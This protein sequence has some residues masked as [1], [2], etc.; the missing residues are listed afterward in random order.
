MIF[1]INPS[2]IGNKLNMKKSEFNNLIKSRKN[3]FNNL[4]NTELI[5]VKKQFPYCEIIY[6]IVLIKAYL[7]N[8]LNFNDIL[9]DCAVRSSNRQNLFKLIHPTKKIN[10]KNKHLE[11]SFEDWLKNSSKKKHVKTTNSFISQSVE[12]SVKNDLNLTT[13][14]LAKIY[15][16]QGHYERAIQAYKVLCLKYP[17]KSGFFANRI[18]EIR[19]KIK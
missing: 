19:N 12:K 9:S 5:S 15:T 11:Y 1:L 6:N 7:N 17:K 3:L 2:S 8:D 18:K 4:N 10:K 13:E 14:T 16:D